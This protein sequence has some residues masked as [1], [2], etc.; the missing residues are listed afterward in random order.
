MRYREGHKPCTYTHRRN[1]LRDA[2][3]W[4]A[5]YEMKAS[6]GQYFRMTLRS[7]WSQCAKT[8]VPAMDYWTGRV[9]ELEQVAQRQV[10]EES[11]DQGDVSNLKSCLETGGSKEW[12]AVIVFAHP[13]TAMAA[14]EQ[15]EG[16]PVMR[17]L[18]TGS[19][20]S[21]L[22]G[23]VT[24]APEEADW[25]WSNVHWS[26]AHVMFRVVLFNF[27]LLILLFFFTTPATMLSA[28]HVSDPNGSF[29]TGLSSALN[30]LS[31][32]LTDFITAW[33]PT[34]MVVVLNNVVLAILEGEPDPSV[35]AV[36]CNR[37][38]PAS[39]SR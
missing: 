9:R 23:L 36:T 20:L 29:L 19:G 25:V 7:H 10:N 5:F 16:S 32:I 18:N 21:G 13:A 4:L 38:A 22:P 37:R 27:P 35:N 31:P 12:S 8:T 11:P 6:E 33:I 30:S 34:V 26:S 3:E 39:C 15:H 24:R 17:F 28:T 14:L 1:D 2:R